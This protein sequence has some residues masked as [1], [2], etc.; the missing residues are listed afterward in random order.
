MD[1][2]TNDI[3]QKIL[4]K[5]LTDRKE[6]FEILL[7]S[8]NKILY[9]KDASKD[10][11]NEKQHYF[12][13]VAQKAMLNGYSILKLFN[14]IEVLNISSGNNFTVFDPSSMVVLS[15]SLLESYLTFNYVYNVKSELESNFK[16]NLW[17]QYGLR[18]RIKTENTIQIEKEEHKSTLENDKI[19]REKLL[20]EIKESEFFK[21][22]HEANH[23]D[24]LKTIKSNW[25]IGIQGNN[26]ISL[27][28]QN[29]LDNTGI[30]PELSKEV[31]NFLSWY[32]HST[33]ISIFQFRDMYV[34]GFSN[35]LLY[36]T[37]NQSSFIISMFISDMVRFDSDYKPGYETLSQEA[38]EYINTYNYILRNNEYTIDKFE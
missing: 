17:L 2:D 37:L 25:K 19:N 10:I 21:A 8:F 30:K 28:W 35:F 32:S 3:S 6:C 4:S 33:C 14:G 16:F 27:G 12:H 24:F 26:F 13:L 31:Y 11:K 22:L 20:T 18:N 7:N 36:N 29:L 38:R 5:D 9:E 1:E 23:S 15:R 34:S